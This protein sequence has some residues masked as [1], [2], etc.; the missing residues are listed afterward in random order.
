MSVAAGYNREK[1]ESL[2][3]NLHHPRILYADVPY[4]REN[5]TSFVTLAF[6]GWKMRWIL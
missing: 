2:I 4:N 6:I 5:S 1:T 3:C